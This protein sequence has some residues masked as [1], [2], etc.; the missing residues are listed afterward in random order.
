MYVCMHIHID[1]IHT[2]TVLEYVRSLQNDDNVI[3]SVYAAAKMCCW[4]L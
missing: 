4:R 3:S 1:Y 2:K